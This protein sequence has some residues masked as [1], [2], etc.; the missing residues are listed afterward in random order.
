[1]ISLFGLDFSNQRPTLTDVTVDAP[2]EAAGIWYSLFEAS[3]NRILP[4][5]KCNF[6][7]HVCGS[8]SGPQA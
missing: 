7:L 4:K 6:A 5:R 2:A 1:M 3:N 8:V